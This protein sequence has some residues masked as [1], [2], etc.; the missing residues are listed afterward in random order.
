MLLLTVAGGVK[1][2][3]INFIPVIHDPTTNNCGA[4]YSDGKFQK[5]VGTFETTPTGY[6]DFTCQ[7]HDRDT[8]NCD[9]NPFCLDTADNDFLYRN[10]SNP[11]VKGILYSSAAK[12]VNKSTRLLTGAYSKK[13]L[14]MSEEVEYDPYH[15]YDGPLNAHPVEKQNLRTVY[16]PVNEDNDNVHI[17][18]FTNTDKSNS[19]PSEV[20]Y[21]SH[22]KPKTDS[23]ASVENRSSAHDEYF[24]DMGGVRVKYTKTE[25]NKYLYNEAKRKLAKLKIKKPKKLKAKKKKKTKNNKIACDFCHK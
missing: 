9:D 6:V 8:Y 12:L 18:T 20:G 23:T 17:G 24:N 15:G 25:Y 21:G 10:F 2:I 3:K 5:S 16:D 13:N 1:L 11:S 7:E 22:T 14:R 4:G 19:E